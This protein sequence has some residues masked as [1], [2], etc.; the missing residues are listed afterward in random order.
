MEKLLEDFI[1]FV[2]NENFN[3]YLK[4]TV[5][6][7][8]ALHFSI[9]I[10]IARDAS[11]RSRNLLFQIF[12]VFLGMLIPLFGLIFYL[13]LRPGKLIFEKV[14]DGFEN[15]AQRN[16]CFFCGEVIRED[17]KFC[18]HCSEELYQKCEKCNKNFSKSFPLCPYCG[19][20]INLEKLKKQVSEQKKETKK[21]KI[22]EKTIEKTSKK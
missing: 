10:W 12:F 15:F 6:I 4:I 7:F 20:K 17:F 19:E 21:K 18:P 2:Q 1:S 14:L 13:L 22:A 8:L 16:C 3:L 9:V 11:N 5:I